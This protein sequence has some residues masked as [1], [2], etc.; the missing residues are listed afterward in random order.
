[1]Q[2]KSPSTQNL[3]CFF[4]IR[5]CLGFT[6]QMMCRQSLLIRGK[7]S[8]LYCTAHS[9]FSS[10]GCVIMRHNETLKTTFLS[11]SKL[12]SNQFNHIDVFLFHLFCAGLPNPWSDDFD[13]YTTKHPV[14]LS[15]GHLTPGNLSP[16]Y[17]T[18]RNYG[19]E[20]KVLMNKFRNHQMKKF[21]NRPGHPIPYPF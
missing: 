17:L 1:M 11:F 9:S 18:P 12:S 4:L 16:G 19:R 10:K 15:S 14:H 5:G 20:L 6:V 13:W 7:K 2:W 8:T 3:F 21:R